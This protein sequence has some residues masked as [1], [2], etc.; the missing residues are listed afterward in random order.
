MTIQRFDD[1]S[2]VL[3]RNHVA[4][5]SPS[6]THQ[7]LIEKINDILIMPSSRQMETK[8]TSIGNYHLESA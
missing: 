7:R 6:H 8:W 1:V 3:A 2:S 4:I 5:I